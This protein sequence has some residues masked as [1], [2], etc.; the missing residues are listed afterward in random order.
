[1]NG[2]GSSYGQKL[3]AALE[4]WRPEAA[5]EGSLKLPRFKRALKGWRRVAPTQTR[6]PMIEYVKSAIS[7]LL[8]WRGRKDMALYNELTFSTYLWPGEA[9]KL[10][11]ADF[12][13]QGGA[14]EEYPHS[15]LVL[16]PFE[17]GES[18]KTGIFDEVVILDD[19]R[20]PWMERILKAHVKSRF[21]SHGEDTDLWNFNA[22]Q[23]L[24]EWRKA[25][26]VL[27]VEDCASSPYQNRHGGASQDHLLHF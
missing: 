19:G 16:A 8:I 3:Q 12:V 18:S 4:F 5:R 6:L 25:V 27:Q 22:K 2:E 7:G 15:I 26:E 20:V 1:M 24:L 14:L 17:R 10:K 21:D 9:L 23:F 11:A 13:S